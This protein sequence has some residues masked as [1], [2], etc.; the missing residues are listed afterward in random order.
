MPG[1]LLLLLLSTSPRLYIYIYI[2]AERKRGTRGNIQVWVVETRTRGREKVATGGDEKLEAAWTR[3]GEERG[4]AD[5]LEQV[6][7]SG[8]EEDAGRAALDQ[9]NTL[10][11]SYSLYLYTRYTHTSHFF[12]HI[13]SINNFFFQFLINNF[14]ICV[15]L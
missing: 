13:F 10:L 9:L 2:Y 12:S 3:C 6:I 8:W 1:L 7:T 5:G 14:R 4:R 11:L 15:L